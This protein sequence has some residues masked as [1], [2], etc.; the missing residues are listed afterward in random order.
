[1]KTATTVRDTATTL[2]HRLIVSHPN[3]Y[4]VDRF[5]ENQASEERIYIISIF[6][7][8]SPSFQL[9]P[10]YFASFSKFRFCG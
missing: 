10:S 6:F 9:F 5:S 1:M 4:L 7:I 2:N 8:L 3:Q